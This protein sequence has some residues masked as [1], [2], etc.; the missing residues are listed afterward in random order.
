MDG[1]YVKVAGKNRVYSNKV[2]VASKQPLKTCSSLYYMSDVSTLFTVNVRINK[3]IVNLNKMQ[4]IILD[5]RKRDHT[6]EY[7]TAAN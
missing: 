6:D 4:A 5:K 2:L 3:I 1:E 7:I